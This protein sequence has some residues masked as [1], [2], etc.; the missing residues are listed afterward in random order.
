MR[1][2]LTGETPYAAKLGGVPRVC[3][4]LQSAELTRVQVMLGLA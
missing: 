4:G 3:T 2:V 1:G